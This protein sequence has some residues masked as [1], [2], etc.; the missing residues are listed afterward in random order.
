MKHSTPLLS[1]LL[2]VGI[3]Q[4]G[5]FEQDDLNQ[6]Y[7]YLNQL[8]LRAG[9]TEL[10]TNPQLELSAFN[11][12]NFLADN[13]LT[14]HY[15]I[16]SLPGFTGIEP[17]DR[18]KAAGYR[19]LAVSENVSSGDTRS[20]DSIDGLMGAI[21]HRFGFLDLVI[22]EIGIGIAKVSL[23][24]PN[25]HTA[26][27]YNMGNSGL[28]ALCEGPAFSGYGRYYFSVCEPD[29]Q[30]NADDFENVQT[31]ARGYNPN[32]VQWPADG[33]NDVPP[34]FFE[35]SPD[36]LPDYSVS[37][38]P[39]SLQFNPLTFSDVNIIAFQLYRE[40]DNSEIQPTRLLNQSTD[41]N[42][43]MTGLQYALFPLER[44]EWNTAYRVEA[45]Y[46]STSSD[47]QTLTWR[48]KTRNLGVPLYTLQGSGEVIS[49]PQNS[50]SFAI[51]I[52][53]TAPYSDMSSINY[54]YESG[55]R[56]NTDF[57]DGNTLRINMTGNVGQQA[58]FTL[59]GGRYFVLQI[60]EAV[61]TCEPATLTSDME[62]LSIPTLYYTP[63]DEAPILVWMNLEHTTDL[64]FQILDYDLTENVPEGCEVS[65]LILEE[66]KLKMHIPTLHY[67]PADEAQNVL[68][69]DFEFLGDSLFKVINHGFKE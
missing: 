11:H 34:A 5:V 9:M 33:D 24:D 54:R 28:N 19:S 13:Y 26:Y 41:P 67:T 45:T 46:Y 57:I 8:R 55:M 40:T 53:P 29:I 6:G 62:R 23:S 50:T 35:E 21:Y 1:L 22:D 44:L 69:V 16:N 60:S 42:A 4:A 58:T 14:G 17:K 56:I 68:W 52:P 66:G 48:F 3:A 18:T 32:I 49:I 43:K 63:P 27:V 31:L 7:A 47:T 61:K 37:G 2:T 64:Q 65:T 20:R 59:S 36:P 15:E 38:Y 25:S 51:Y 10:F 30:I 39:V 12:A